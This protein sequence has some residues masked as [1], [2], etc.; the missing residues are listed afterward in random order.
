MI[1]RVVLFST[2]AIKR[3]ALLESMQGCVLFSDDVAVDCLKPGDTE[4]PQP[5]SVGSALDCIA[6]RIEP[7]LD[8]IKA[9]A[10][11]TL[12]VVVENYIDVKDSVFDNVAV[13]LLRGGST[14][15][16][17]L[18]A[19]PHARVDVPIELHDALRAD[20][21]RIGRFKLFGCEKT[22]GQRLHDEFP[23]CPH[24][25][26]FQHAD[27]T[28]FSRQRQIRWALERAFENIEAL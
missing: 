28:S 22:V 1:H 4:C 17:E 15:R 14:K 11:S 16:I 9:T 27:R 24:D 25:D 3:D 7:H 8:L 18:I 23:Q 5:A 20:A 19:P 2:S 21:R 26:W 13:A 12:F 6:C 10:S